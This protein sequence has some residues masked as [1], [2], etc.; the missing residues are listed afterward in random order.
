MSRALARSVAGP[1]RLACAI[2]G[3]CSVADGTQAQLGTAAAVLRQDVGRLLMPVPITITLAGFGA[4]AIAH[5]W[6]DDV[7]GHIDQP[8][9]GEI[10]DGGRVFGS[11]N[12][13]TGAALVLCGQPPDRLESP[14]PGQLSSYG[15]SSWRMAW[16]P[17]SNS[18]SGA[19]GR[20]A[21]TIAHFPR[22]FRQR[23]R[24]GNNPRPS[25]ISDDSNPR[26]RSRRDCADFTDPP[27]A[28]T[29]FRMS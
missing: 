27:L 7:H 21:A 12:A 19:A 2:I 1:L 13:V 4:A 8:M 9:I 10:V 26:I 28:G 24:S 6:D 17:P 29:L 23:F 14:S 22:P 11:M 15:P 3:L 25:S 18:P 16:L 5:R 20:T